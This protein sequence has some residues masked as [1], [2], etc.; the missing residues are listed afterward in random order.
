MDQPNF[1]F[2]QFYEQ[3]LKNKGIKLTEA[4]M[5]DIKYYSFVD[6]WD[7]YDQS[8]SIGKSEGHQVVLS[9]YALWCSAS[10]YFDDLG[11]FKQLNDYDLWK[12]WERK[13]GISLGLYLAT[14]IVFQR[15]KYMLYSIMRSDE[16]FNNYKNIIQDDT[17]ML[18]KVIITQLEK[19]NVNNM[20]IK[21]FKELTLSTYEWIEPFI[22]AANNEVG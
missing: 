14:S 9:C 20:I 8:C 3:L 22:E 10:I 16:R 6:Y 17:A 18:N 11:D 7:N 12:K 2:Q 5:Q 1:S 21:E 15:N 19:H 13:S 4:D